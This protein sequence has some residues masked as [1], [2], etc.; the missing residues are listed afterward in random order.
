MLTKPWTVALK[1]SRKG[2]VCQLQHFYKLIGENEK[3]PPLEKEDFQEL[4]GPA[5]EAG[6]DSGYRL[7]AFE[8]ADIDKANEA[9]EY[10]EKRNS[11][12]TLSAILHAHPAVSTSAM[13]LGMGLSMGLG[14][15][16]LGQAASAYSRA[17]AAQMD[18]LHSQSI[19][20]ARKSSLL[21]QYQDRVQQANSAG[22]EI[23]HIDKQIE[24]QK[25][26]IEITN[27]EIELQQRRLELAVD[28]DQFLRA[29]Y[30]NEDLYMWREKQLRDLY[31]QTYLL[32]YDL[33]KK[34]ENSFHFE[35]GPVPSFGF[36]RGYPVTNFIQ[37]TWDANKDGLFSGEE[38][39]L[40]LKR[41]EVAYNENRGY[42]YEITK[43]ISLRQLNPRALLEFR[44]LGNCEFDIP[45][46]LFDMDFPGHYKRRIKAVSLTIVPPPRPSITSVNCTM[47]LV[48]HSYRVK[49][50]AD[51]NSYA[52]GWANQADGSFHTDVIPIDHIATSNG[53][54]DN[55]LFQP[56]PS[57]ERYAPFEGAGAISRWKLEL[58]ANFRMFDYRIMT[59]VVVQLRYTAV[60]GGDTLKSIANDYV[61]SYLKEV[62]SHKG[63]MWAL[64]DAKYD[65][66]NEW[67]EF[68]SSHSLSM[69]NL[70]D[71]LPYFANRYSN[72][73]T[74]DEI[75]LF[76]STKVDA[77][78]W[79][80]IVPSGPTT[81]R[82]V[83]FNVSNTRVLN[84]YSSGAKL[85][86]PLGNWTLQLLRPDKGDSLRDLWVVVQYTLV[87]R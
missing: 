28:T 29:K 35:R 11:A 17:M 10:I 38:L 25:A 4:T 75:F 56:A 3:R 71:R 45:E 69:P 32:G 74:V 21:R 58:P 70:D 31:Y 13:P 24:V 44:E 65:F 49:V 26:R 22:H 36:E 34:A 77:T 79:K 42:D 12:E 51:E 40:G 39:Y 14:S 18:L 37:G 78:K 46:V 84:C 64:F 48:R 55:G 60:Y 73:V 85:D 54:K 76:T 19:G 59:D 9:V 50:A 86:C 53:Q 66:T 5:V 15:L 61:D 2:P 57:D 41:L 6:R 20:A 16:K 52:K 33:A 72:R 30:T 68:R 23:K 47:R 1:E 27:Q 80:M 43:Q 67:K 7:N 81:T 83:T 62:K 82:E 87:R 63:G 8:I